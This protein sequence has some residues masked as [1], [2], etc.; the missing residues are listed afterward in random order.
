MNFLSY[1][2]V[3]IGR[4]FRAKTTWLVILLT[5]LCPLIGYSF[6][7]LASATTTASVALANPVLAGGLCGAV[8]FAFL[9]FFEFN[10]VCRA[11]IDHLM[12]TI[13]S[14]CKAVFPAG[15]GLG[16]C[17]ADSGSLSA[18]YRLSYRHSV[19]CQRLCT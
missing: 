11:H 17:I 8:L 1:L 19:Q 3:D 2:K 16:V 9:T 18:L 10:R 5:A 14:P 6:Y 15:D 13:V 12:D 4:L 7:Q